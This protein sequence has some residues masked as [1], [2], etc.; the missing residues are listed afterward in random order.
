MSILK[1][2]KL[3]LKSLYS[4][5]MKIFEM[6]KAR[7]FEIN[8][9]RGFQISFYAQGLEHQ[10]SIC[11][12]I[13]VYENMNQLIK[14]INFYLKNSDLRETIANSGYIRTLNHHDSKIRLREILMKIQ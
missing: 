12:D 10:Y 14:K 6:V 2:Y 7:F 1:S 5:D 4:S 11:N 13:E 3:V 8:A 9:C